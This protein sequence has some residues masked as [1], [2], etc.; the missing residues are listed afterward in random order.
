[1]PKF[2]L[3][4][5]HLFI[6]RYRKILIALGFS[7]IVW[8]IAQ[9]PPEGN[10]VLIANQFIPA[11]TQLLPEQFSEVRISGFAV[12]DF[13]TN[14]S[15]LT[16]AYS[17]N[18][19]TSGALVMRDAITAKSISDDRVD[20]FISLENQSPI[21]PGTKLHLWSDQEEFKQL[22]SSDALVRTSEVDNYGT[23]LRVSIP[24]QDEYAVMQSDS[25]K[26]V[27]VN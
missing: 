13:V 8:S 22:V 24:M 26:I 23:R 17:K 9:N 27:M 2:E 15:E 16:S 20:V 5:I 19:I 21:N 10:V 11:S 1:M 3:N 6:L 7:F 12:D 14:I 18:N 4:Q 25:I